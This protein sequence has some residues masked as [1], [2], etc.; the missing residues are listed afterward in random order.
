MTRGVRRA[1]PGPDRPLPVPA[2]PEA[3]ALDAAWT[4]TFGAGAPYRLAEELARD[5][6]TPGTVARLHDLVDA[7]LAARSGVTRAAGRPGQLAALLARTAHTLVLMAP[8]PVDA[9][10]DW[11]RVLATGPVWH[12]VDRPGGL[13]YAGPGERRPLDVWTARVPHRL[14][15]L[16]Y[17]AGLTADEAARAGTLDEDDLRTLAALRGHPVS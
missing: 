17:A 14:A 16:A 1:L 7:A 3:R 15:P 8:L 12:A 11:L 4:A 9:V 5:G 10:F 13:A 6:W 2:T